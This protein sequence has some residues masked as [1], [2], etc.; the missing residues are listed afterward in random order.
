MRH[1]SEVG[2]QGSA[3]RHPFE[4]RSGVQ[5]KFLCQV[6]VKN[7]DKGMPEHHVARR[8]HGTRTQD[9][10]RIG[11]CKKFLHDWWRSVA[12]NRNDG[13]IGSRVIFL[14]EVEGVMLDT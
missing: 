4:F 6:W 11:Y 10:S 5:E 1:L 8:W 14:L 7:S 13:F 2:N 3:D 9:Y 12:L